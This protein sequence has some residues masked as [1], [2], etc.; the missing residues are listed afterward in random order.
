MTYRLIRI[1]QK[2]YYRKRWTQISPTP[3]LAQNS[4]PARLPNFSLP[5][6][7]AEELR[8]A[9]SPT[10]SCDHPPGNPQAD[11]NSSD[12]L[13]SGCEEPAALQTIPPTRFSVPAGTF[14]HTMAS[15]AAAPPD[16]IS[17]QAMEGFVVGL[18][19]MGDMGK[20]YAQKLSA[21]GWK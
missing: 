2:K 19:G 18:I 7:Q 8:R 16:A 20:M 15:S 11:Q 14:R 4:A 9:A 1:K 17:P 12:S 6:S 13:L 5:P 3:I 21:A 10:Q